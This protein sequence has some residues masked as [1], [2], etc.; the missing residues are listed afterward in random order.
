MG[1]KWLGCLPSH[2]RCGAGRQ[3]LKLHAIPGKRKPLSRS[4][5]AHADAY[6]CIAI[7]L[8]IFIDAMHPLHL[9]HQNFEPNLE[10]IV[11]EY[12]KSPSSHVSNHVLTHTQPFEGIF[13]WGG[14]AERSS[15]CWMCTH[16]TQTSIPSFSKLNMLS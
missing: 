7:F 14:L 12:P 6:I 10:L 1:R 13:R 2:L 3:F 9:N 16:N 11:F 8:E 15:L 5:H 4:T